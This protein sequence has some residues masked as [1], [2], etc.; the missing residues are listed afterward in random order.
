MINYSLKFYERFS[1]DQTFGSNQLNDVFPTLIVGDIDGDFAVGFSQ[2]DRIA[3]D[4]PE[5]IRYYKHACMIGD[6]ILLV[7]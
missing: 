5:E 4:S 2:F 3:N 1:A 7:F 6:S